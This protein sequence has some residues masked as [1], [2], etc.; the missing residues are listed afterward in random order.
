VQIGP[1]TVVTSPLLRS[2]LSFI[3]NLLRVVSF[4]LLLIF[5][6]LLLLSLSAK[7]K[8]N[9]DY[10]LTV[11]RE[12]LCSHVRRRTRK[13]SFISSLSI[14]QALSSH[15]RRRTRRT[16]F[17]SSSSILQ[18][19]SSYTHRRSTSTLFVDHRRSTSTLFV[20]HAS[21]R[22]LLFS[23]LRLSSTLQV[24]PDVI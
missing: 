18:S 15:A 12:G 1:S 22:P 5:V 3:N 14:L 23:L 9:S 11:V 24:L 20:D 2:Q 4:L 10:T 19:L 21:L 8:T 16:S 7:P 17:I 13:T 6:P